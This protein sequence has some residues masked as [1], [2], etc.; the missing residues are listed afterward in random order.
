VKVL[1]LVPARGGSRG[2]PR[3]NLRMVAG[4]PLIAWTIDCAL[5]AECIAR[6]VVSTDDDEIATTAESLGAEVPFIRPAELASDEIL[7]LP[8]YEHALEWL[9]EHQG[10]RP[11]AVAWLRPTAPLRTTADIDA[12]VAALE[13]TDAGCVRS[14]CQAEHHPYWMKRIEDER[15]TPFIGGA[16]E[17]AYPRRQLL[18]PVYRL[19]GAVDVVRCSAVAATGV[20][21]PLPMAPYVMPRDRSVD[22]DDPLDLRAAEL[23][24]ECR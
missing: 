10:Y 20:L 23:H 3:K 21:Y 17:L 18:P 7:D 2:L 24:L 8:V 13:Q 11:D 19:N 15:L 12:A 5:T 6:V 9:A 22:I 4:R 14:V 16:D 1:A